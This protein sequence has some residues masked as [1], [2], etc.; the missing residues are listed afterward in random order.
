MDETLDEKTL[1]LFGEVLF[2]I[3]PDGGRVLGGA[4]FNLAWHLQAFGQQP[5][6]VSRLGNDVAGSEIRAAMREWGMETDFLQTDP[7]RPTGR[8]EVHIEAGEP[9]F[10]IVPDCAY[11]FISEKELGET[12][13]GLLYHGSLALRNH[14]SA[15]ALRR[16]KRDC[17]GL[18][19]LDVNLRPPWWKREDVI[20]LINDADWVKLNEQELHR[21]DKEKGPLL[22][23]AETFRDAY[24]LKGL[25]ITR[26]QAGAL[27]VTE[28]LEPIQVAPSE[29]VQV[30]DT[31]GAGDA[32]SAVLLLGIAN[33]W[34][35]KLTMERAQSFASQLVCR[36]GAI[37]QDMGFYRLLVAEWHLSESSVQ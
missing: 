6:L 21:L 28:R 31:V 23:R 14:V 35:L 20:Q 30:V 4:P 10:D 7:D 24:E 34:P 22:K 3:F 2:D 8:V 5:R 18:L 25:V 19:F 9:S 15:R 16:L 13:C 27:A 37:V 32:F 29:I 11:D 1:C 33:A 26:G 36:Q 12:A 17:K